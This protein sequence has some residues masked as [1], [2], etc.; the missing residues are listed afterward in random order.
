MRGFRPCH[1]RMG[2]SMAEF[3]NRNGYLS[4][5]QIAYWRVPMKKG[6]MR[7]AIY[8]K[9]LLAEAHAKASAKAAIVVSD[10]PGHRQE[11]PELYDK[12]SFNRS[13]YMDNDPYNEQ[14]REAYEAERIE[15]EEYKMHQLEAAADRAQTIRD[16][17]NKAKARKAM[18]V[19]RVGDNWTQQQRD[20]IDRV[21]ARVAARVA[22]KK[23]V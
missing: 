19:P 7:I 2:S 9:Q 6:G 16:E 18:E 3:Y 23:G 17:T 10:E 14:E 13:L 5:K 15:H 21:R 8:W 12:P 1:A 20:V 4:P 11:A 22:A